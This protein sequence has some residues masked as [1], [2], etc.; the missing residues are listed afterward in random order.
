MIFFDFRQT[1]VG[2]SF[3]EHC[4]DFPEPVGRGM[5]LQRG[6]DLRSD[7]F[8][9]GFKPPVFGPVFRIVPIDPT[10]GD[11]SYVPVP[12]GKR[13][14][15]ISMPEHH[16]PFVLREGK[17]FSAFPSGY[18]QDATNG[19]FQVHPQEA[20]M[21]GC[22]LEIG[23]ED[24]LFELI[25]IQKAENAGALVFEAL[26]IDVDSLL[27]LSGKDFLLR[28][29]VFVFHFTVGCGLVDQVPLRICAIYINFSG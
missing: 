5:L 25:I 1:G 12:A 15:K 20:P 21:S 9:D 23:I 28:W 27:D 8:H 26:E 6:G 13:A 3:E 19:G 18:F 24:D 4:L 16:F 17:D 29:F 7:V 14:L 22:F 10:L 2:L 11:D